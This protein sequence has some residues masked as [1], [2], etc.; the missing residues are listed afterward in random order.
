MDNHRNQLSGQFQL[1]D[2]RQNQCLDNSNE[3]NH[4]N[5]LSGQCQIVDNRRNQ[6]PGQ[7]QLI[8]TS[9]KS[10]ADTIRV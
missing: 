1:I 6:L 3:D 8:D 2:N 4:R 10:I 9:P 5:Q 7:L